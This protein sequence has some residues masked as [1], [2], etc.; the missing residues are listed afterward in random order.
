[1]WSGDRLAAL[2]SS[3]SRRLLRL[4]LLF[5]VMAVGTPTMRDCRFFFTFPEGFS[6][7]HQI[8][9]IGVM[10]FF[11]HRLFIPTL[12]RGIS[13][14]WL[15]DISTSLR[16]ADLSAAS[17]TWRES[18][19]AA[20]DDAATAASLFFGIH[21]FQACICRRKLGQF[22][23]PT[24]W[25]PPVVFVGW[26]KPSNIPWLTRSIYPAWTLIPF[27]CCTFSNQTFFFLAGEAMIFHDFPS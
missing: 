21:T 22:L 13:F 15:V 26:S 6:L 10:V 14:L 4:M 12:S 1:M 9:L 24:M 18:T 16:E 23:H 5:L 20:T 2:D 8:T 25:C 19:D 11:W 3:F 17:P 27:A 7:S